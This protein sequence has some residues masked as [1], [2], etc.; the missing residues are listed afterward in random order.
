MRERKCFV[1]K[2]ADVEVREREFLLIKGGERLSVEPKAFRVLLFLLRNPGR[3]INKDEI[4]ASVWSD[5]AVSDNSLTRSIAQLRRVLDDDSREPQYI[6][7]VPTLGYRFLCEVAVREDGFGV[8]HGT[9]ATPPNG[10][11]PSDLIGET[12]D[13]GDSQNQR[14]ATGKEANSAGTEDERRET[15]AA[16]KWWNRKRIYA[17]FAIALLIFPAG[18]ILRS[19]FGSKF[20]PAH[21]APHMATEQRLTAN[22]FEVPISNAVVSPDGKYVAYAD[23]TGLYLRQIS[24]GETRPLS[25]P[26]GFVAWPE[27]W[28]PDGTHL[29]VRRIAAEPKDLSLGLWQSSLYELSILGGEPQEI[30]ND[31]AA[32]Y[33]SPDGSRIAYLPMPNVSEVW[34]PNANEMWMID[35][36]GTNPRRVV[37][38][39]EKKYGI[40]PNWIDPAAWSPTG[41]HLAYIENHFVAAAHPVEPTRS[42]RIIGSNGEGAR[43]VL[44]DPRIG[45]ALWW[46]PDGRIFFSYREDPASRLENYGVYSIR[47]DERTGMA[48][49]L[50]QPVTQAEGSIGS[51]SGTADGKRLVVWRRSHGPQ[52]FIASFDAASRR[53]NEPRRLTLD[54]NMN[55]GTAWTADS[56]AVLFISNRNGTWKL[57]KQGIDETTPEVLAEAQGIAPPRLSADGSQVL[58]MSSSNPK[59]VSVPSSIMSKSLSG[60]TPRVVIPRVGIANY[61]CAMSPSTLCIFS[62]LD[63]HDLIFRSFDLEHGAGRELLRIPD[64]SPDWSLSSDGSKLA[65]ILDR[66]RIRVVHFGTGASYEVTVKDWPLARGDWAANSQTLFMPSY[67]PN[68]LPVILE[69]DQ[70]GKAK[71]VLRGN[72]NID[73]GFVIQSPDGRNG[74]VCESVPSDSNAWMVDDF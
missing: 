63:G 2:F 25:L 17:A 57:F 32:G 53:W 22:P 62:Q 12:V 43:L 67:A 1:F 19:F 7:T 41:Q 48:A 61:Q 5:S 68:G 16:N 33:V 10:E 69:V 37:S 52:V 70:T 36:D 64:G 73:F 51:M 18:F 28:F 45:Q 4:V 24:S 23:P 11:H 58:Y 30:V 31:A 74:L 50:P 39:G 40:H 59:D 20:G 29:L 56:K 42:L 6:L 46:A 27:S 72:A 9:G 8:G 49:G 47:V 3:L 14:H 21:T 71:V 54:A 35:S 66:H 44:D 55:F 34:A 13:A 65:V 26:K 15:N 38:V 60:G